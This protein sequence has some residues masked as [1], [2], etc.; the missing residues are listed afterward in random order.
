MNKK[1]F[2]KLID[3]LE[4]PNEEFYILG[5]GSLLMYGIRE[6]ANDLDLCISEE[7]FENLKIEGRIDLNSKNECGF[8]KINDFVEVVVNEKKNFEFD[9]IDGYKVE[10]LEKI[11]KFKESRN[12]EKDCNDILKIREYLMNKES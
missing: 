12:K 4:L 1:D 8:Y 10:K 9:V 3:S 11:L 2:V 5:G 6:N 7:L